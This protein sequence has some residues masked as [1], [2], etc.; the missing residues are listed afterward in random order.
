MALMDAFL[1]YIAFAAGPPVLICYV[2]YISRG[3]PKTFSRQKVQQMRMLQEIERQLL[4][5][6]TVDTEN[7]AR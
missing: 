1:A 6:G 2:C 5:D 7:E 4:A 3:R